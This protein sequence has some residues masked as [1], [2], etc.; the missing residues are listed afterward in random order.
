[1]ETSASTTISVGLLLACPG[2]Q[3][4]LGPSEITF[5][6]GVIQN[7]SSC[8]AQNNPLLALPALVN[9]HDHGRG[10]ASFTY[11]ARDQPLEL[12][13]PALK[14]KPS[15]SVYSLTALA[16]AK[17][18]RSGI[19]SVVHCH[20]PNGGDLLT[21]VEAV[22][23]AARDVGMRLALAVP[24]ND[25]NALAYGDP[26]RLLSLVDPADRDHVQQIWNPPT[27]SPADQLKRVETIAQQCEGGLVYVQYC[28]RG[29][30]WCSDEMLEAIAVASAATG[31]RIHTHLLETRYQREWADTQYP[32]GLIRY[33]DEIGFLSPRLTVAHGVWLR[34]DELALLA[35]RGVIISVNTSSNLR[36]R[37]GIAP[38]AKMQAAGVA[39]AFG[40]DGMSLND[41]ADAF[42]EIRLSYHLH[43]TQQAN[44][45]PIDLLAAQRQGAK[46]VT[47]R[48]DIGSL[49]PGQAADM[50][51]LNY[52]A[53]SCDVVPQVAD[54]SE[55]ILA[56]A[57]NQYVEALW[58]NGRLIVE[59]G[60]VLGVDEPMI[61]TELRSLLKA[62]A[63][64]VY[65]LQPLVQRYQQALTQF[66]TKDW[67][68]LSSANNS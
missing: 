37:S 21:E 42:R 44:L 67:H 15:L 60:K 41:D 38:L 14:L 52:E 20:N 8:P 53:L 16:L 24:L 47:N 26:Q 22:C 2:E 6:K 62:Q 56:R 49:Q 55:L 61:A 7:I 45:A 58:V 46:A 12:W 19:G 3:P 63:Q 50:V 1:M 29:P 9:A 66:Y 17:M 25:R 13:L 51:L 65:S 30:Q 36:L 33:L 57:S 34:P 23:Q 68:Q 28:P 59:H 31:R 32:Q 5:A 11:G 54:P 27:L 48:N 64:H 10:L 35:E 4:I 43:A 39:I 40:L 18:A